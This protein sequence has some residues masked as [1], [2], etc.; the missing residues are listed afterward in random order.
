MAEKKSLKQVVVA[1][2]TAELDSPAVNTASR[3]LLAAVVTVALA[4]VHTL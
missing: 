4:Y 1:F 2:V 3:A